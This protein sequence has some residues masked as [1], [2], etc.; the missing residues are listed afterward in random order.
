M[1]PGSLQTATLTV[2]AMVAFAANSLLTRLA[3]DGGTIDAASFTSIR[4]AAGAATL[5]ALTGR[6]LHRRGTD[7][8]WVRLAGP[9]ALFVYAAPFSFAYLRIGAGVGALVLFG[10]VQLTNLRAVLQSVEAGEMSE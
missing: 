3:L 7:R 4:L 10:S 8:G 5:V 9:V 6:R 2:L 1:A